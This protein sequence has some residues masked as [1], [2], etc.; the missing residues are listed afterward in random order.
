MGNDNPKPLLICSDGSSI[1]R[2]IVSTQIYLYIDVNGPNKGPNRYGFDVFTF[3]I[4]E[5][6]A[7]YPMKQER[8]WTKE[9]LENETFSELRG[10]P[11]SIKSNQ[12]L[13]GMGC[14][15]YALNDINPD[16]KTKKYWDSLPW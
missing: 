14:A 2:Y 6:D 5:K 3:Y 11:C 16:D 8:V 9:E 15:W 10:Y 7:V 1:G 13:N 12:K 4:L